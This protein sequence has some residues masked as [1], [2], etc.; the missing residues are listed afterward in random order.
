MA[1]PT[2][3]QKDAAKA[4]AEEAELAKMEAEEKAAAEAAAK[5]AEPESGPEHIYRA[6]SSFK[7]RSALGQLLSFVEGDILEPHV[8]A[9]LF[10]TGA[11]VSREPVGDPEAEG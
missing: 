2:Q 3:A 10:G 7:A 8:G 4:A 1:E 11:H 5:A 6:L 9:H